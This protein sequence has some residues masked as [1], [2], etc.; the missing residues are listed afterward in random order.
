MKG[1]LTTSLVALLAGSAMSAGAAEPAAVLR[2][3]QGRVFVSQ[4][5]TMGPAREGMPVS[6]GNRVVTVAGG[7]VEIVY[8]DGC[9][10]RL[11][12]NSLLAVKGA[13]QCRLGSKGRAI[14]GFQK[15]RIGQAGPLPTTGSAPPKDQPSA[16]LAA[17]GDNSSSGSSDQPIADLKQPKGR[18]LIKEAATE[19]T[20]THNMDVRRD[21]RIVTGKGSRVTVV[22]RGCE[23]DVGPQEQLAMDAL[24]ARCQEGIYPVSN[25]EPEAAIAITKQPQ[26]NVRIDQGTTQRAARHDMDLYRDNRVITGAGAQVRVV[27]KGC[28]VVVEEEKDVAVKDLLTQC[29]GGLWVDSGAGAAGGAGG[30]GGVGGAAISG[31][32]IGIGMPIFIG[33]VV[34]AGAIAINESGDDNDASSR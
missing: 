15:E 21:D 19:K 18:V 5:A 30:A 27:F 12:E 16:A 29:K 14:N 10:M 7:Q 33:G 22:F 3:P 20:A 11:S 2:Q 6:A 31:A 17:A 28:E 9:T 8:S 24:Q 23:V 32:G 25:T 1:Y 13:E 4:D 34:V 26:G